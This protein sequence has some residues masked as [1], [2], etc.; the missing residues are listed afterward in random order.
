M[1][2]K[3]GP[4]AGR[5]VMELGPGESDLVAQPRDA[6]K[7]KR[8]LVPLDFS[9]CSEKA[10][11]YAVAFTEQ[12]PASLTLLYVVEISYGAGEAAI[13]DLQKTKR[14]MV[15]EAKRKLAVSA[16][17]IP[18]SIR[19]RTVVETGIAYDEIIRLARETET[20]LIIIS[21][22]GR[23][24]LKRFFM[25]STTEKVVRH[26]SCPVLV[27]REQEHDFVSEKKTLAKSETLKR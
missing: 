17:T 2:V 6:L 16:R 27:V 4:R 22:H 23:S 15:E 20:D 11:Q 26:A 8:I 18:K 19:V 14:E 25:G 1:K 3:L 5:V 24:G 12:F 21:T 10:L 7:L 13:I 9:E